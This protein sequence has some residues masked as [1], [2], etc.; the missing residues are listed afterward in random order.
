MKLILNLLLL[1][2][3]FNFANA[4]QFEFKVKSSF[5]K[6]EKVIKFLHQ[7]QL[8]PGS[9]YRWPSLA[10]IKESYRKKTGKEMP[11]D[12]QSGYEVLAALENSQ[13]KGAYII[14]TEMKSPVGLRDKTT[15]ELVQKILKE[16]QKPLE[17]SR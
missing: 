17:A 12:I 1:M 13:L 7:A 11:Q 5:A 8:L 10:D 6:S 16:N 3:F 4:E 15:A 14:M 9:N 2:A